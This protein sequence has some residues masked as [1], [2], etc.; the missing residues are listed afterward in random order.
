MSQKK[1]SAEE[2]IK[3]ELDI[4]VSD[5]WEEKYKAEYQELLDL[6][7]EDEKMVLD[8][9]YGQEQETNLWGEEVLPEDEFDEERFTDFVNHVIHQEEQD[10]G[11]FWS[12]KALKEKKKRGRPKKVKQDWY[13]YTFPKTTPIA[14]RVIKITKKAFNKIRAIADD[15]DLY[16]NAEVAGFMYG[17]NDVITKVKKYDCTAS[18][19][20]VTG[21]PIDVFN[22]AKKKKYIGLFHSHLFDSSSPSG[23]DKEVLCGWTAYSDMVER[24]PPI[25]IITRSPRWKMR[26]YSMNKKFKLFEN[27]LIII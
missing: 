12:N 10:I 26:A 8:K 2:L 5:D 3:E 6:Y 15:Q 19:G 13:G 14:K 23:T 22:Q 18:W 17:K 4:D 27:N 21:N 11:D 20:L 7:T 24:L 1:R 16:R 25:M 9:I